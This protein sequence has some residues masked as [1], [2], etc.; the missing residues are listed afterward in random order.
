MCGVIFSLSAWRSGSRLILEL[1]NEVGA[2]VAGVE[3]RRLLVETM[4]IAH[5]FQTQGVLVLPVLVD[6][7]LAYTRRLGDGIHAGGIDAPF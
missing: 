3:D 1:G 2:E 6:G 7:G 4:Q 5:H